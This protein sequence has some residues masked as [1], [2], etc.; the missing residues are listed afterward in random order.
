MQTDTRPH[1]STRGSDDPAEL[2]IGEEERCRKVEA[3]DERLRDSHALRGAY[4]L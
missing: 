3:R 1:D 4:R 2:R